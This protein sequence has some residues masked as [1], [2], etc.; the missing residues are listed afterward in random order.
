MVSPATQ[1]RRLP[2]PNSANGRSPS[3]VS[4]HCPVWKKASRFDQA[5]E[6]T[7]GGNGQTQ[8]VDVLGAGHVL[9]IRVDQSSSG[10]EPRSSAAFPREMELTIALRSGFEERWQFVDEEIVVATR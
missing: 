10:L 8:A 1:L 2:A 9:P 3:E 6:A 5:E 7:G 4:Q